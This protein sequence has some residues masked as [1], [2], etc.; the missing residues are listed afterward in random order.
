M[1]D[2]IAEGLNQAGAQ[3]LGTGAVDFSC[4][5]EDDSKLNSP[6]SCQAIVRGS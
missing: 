3:A 1:P 5:N 6:S 4:V 2:C